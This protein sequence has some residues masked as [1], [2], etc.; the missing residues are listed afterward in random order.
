MPLTKLMRASTW[1]SPNVL[2][3]AAD[4]L[5]VPQKSQ[6]ACATSLPYVTKAVVS[7]GRTWPFAVWSPPNDSGVPLPVILFLHGA[8]ER[9]IDGHAPAKVGLAPAL[10]RFPERYPAHVVMPQCPVGLQWSGPVLNAAIATLEETIQ[11]TASDER[12]I[13]LTGI[14][15]GAHGAFRLAARQ[16]SRFAALVA[17][18]GWGDA[19]EIAKHLKH[20]PTWLFHG[21]ADPIVPARCSA[22]LATALQSAGADEV[23]HTEYPGVGHESWDLAYADPALPDWLFA[24]SR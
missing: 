7:G 13:Y 12:R 8:G 23:R 14:S 11:A 2:L 3:R 18:C 9:G 1:I 21:A 22:A 15:M 5:G 6:A 10:C 16:P 24:R 20:L 17:I 19:N 4:L